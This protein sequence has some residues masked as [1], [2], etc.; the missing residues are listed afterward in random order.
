MDVFETAEMTMRRI[1]SVGPIQ[2]HA[3]NLKS[4]I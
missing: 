4:G 1:V 3:L 2:T